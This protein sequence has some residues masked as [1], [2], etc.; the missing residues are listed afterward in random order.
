MRASLV[1]LAGATALLWL[2]VP[3]CGNDPKR[4]PSLGLAYVGPAE[5]KIRADIPLQSPAV[6]TVRHGEQLEILQ[7]RRG[8]FLKVRT[9]QGA[10]GWTEARQLL[11][12]AEV[13]GMKDLAERARKMPSQGAAM[14]YGELRVHVEPSRT[15][16]S[17]MLIKEKDKVDVLA[18]VVTPR[19]GVARKPL[20]PPPPPKKT[21]PKPV[22]PPKESKYP[23]PPPPKPPEP[24][25]N[26]LELSQAAQPEDDETGPSEPEEKEEKSVPTDRW[27]LVRTPSGESGWVLTRNLSMAIPDDVAQYAEGHRIVSYFAIGEVTD[28]EAVKKEW[29]WTTTSPGQPYDFDSFRVFVWSLKRHRYETSYIERNIK[30]YSPVFLSDVDLSTG[31]KSKDRTTVKSPGF[32]LCVEKADGQRMRREY[33]FLNPAVRFVGER[34]CEAAAPILGV[35]AAPAPAAPPPAPKKEPFGQKMKRWVHAV[36]PRWLG[37]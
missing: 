19:S 4:Q 8:A 26:W 24:P 29:L 14:T 36:T 17:F 25:A 34:P 16:P 21:A 37:G 13:A 22:K 12:P 10:E 28:G 20:I 33:A 2:C 35:T 6:A 5:L 15:A 3:G 1:W 23:L 30:G 9:R 31:G 11:T 7:Q 27:S 32:S 18:E